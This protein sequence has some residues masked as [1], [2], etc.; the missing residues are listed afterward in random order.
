MRWKK[1]AAVAA[2]ACMISCLYGC[3]KA[4]ADQVTLLMA[5]VQEGEHPTALACDKFADMVYDR[6]KGRINIEVYHGSTLGTEA[7]QMAQVEAGGLDFARVST[8][9]FSDD[10]Y[11]QAFQC[12]YLYDSED[13]MWDT[14]NGSVGDALLAL[15]IDAYDNIEGLCWFSGG[16]RN[17]YNNQ[18]AIHTPDDLNGLTLRVTAD[19]L[20]AL[21]EMNGATGINVSY[22]DI[23][24]SITQGV[25]DGAENNWP[26][27]I[28]TGHYEV[29]QYITIDQHQC[30]PE[31][32]IASQSCLD[33][34]SAEDRAI[35]EECAKEVSEYQIQAMKDY[36]ADALATAEAA[37]VEVT[38]LTDA[39][40]AQFHEQG[41]EVN[42]TVSEHLSDAIA[43]VTG[44]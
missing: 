21:L 26:S 16:S 18:H 12:L 4:P 6:T 38:Y 29:A 36:E 37:G 33:S 39:E 41:A 20:F 30:V 23:Y 27:Y 1:T 42:A 17:F 5:D 13:A 34:L 15:D 22:N 31:L 24:T 11:F 35:I 14:L 32:I 19:S 8:S 7:E 2:L 44:K 25:I 10:P 28:S 9:V 3:G 43:F 40:A